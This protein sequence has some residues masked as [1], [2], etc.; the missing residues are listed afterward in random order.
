MIFIFLIKNFLFEI[1]YIPS[2]SMFPK[3]NIGDFI[4]INKNFNIKKNIKEVK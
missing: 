2:N 1:F 4:F 3:F